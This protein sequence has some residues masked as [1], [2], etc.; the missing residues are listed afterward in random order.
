MNENI[1]MK[2]IISSV[3]FGTLKLSNDN[4]NNNIRWIIKTKRRGSIKS[5][6]RKVPVKII[7]KQIKSMV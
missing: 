3:N 5:K 7:N 6:P 4:E 1:V 2:N